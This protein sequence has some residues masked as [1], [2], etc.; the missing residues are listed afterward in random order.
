MD[1]NPEETLVNWTEAIDAAVAKLDAID[2]GDPEMAHGE[3]DEILLSVV[4]GE[5]LH[6]YVRLTRRCSWWACA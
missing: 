4:P 3:A 5:V 2:A 1:M 6:A